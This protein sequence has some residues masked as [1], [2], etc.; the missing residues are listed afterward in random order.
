MKNSH[1]FVLPWLKYSKKTLF[2][3]HICLITLQKV[4]KILGKGAKIQFFALF[5]CTNH[6]YILNEN[7]SNNKRNIKDKKNHDFNHGKKILTKKNGYLLE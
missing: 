1:L 3:R 7:R 2:C 6:I 5:F 4:A